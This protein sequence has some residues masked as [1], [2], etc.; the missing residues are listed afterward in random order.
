MRMSAMR[1][2]GTL[3]GHLIYRL[4]GGGARAWG[5]FASRFWAGAGQG[6]GSIWDTKGRG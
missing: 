6:M 2:N 1:R 5:G 3:A 4:G